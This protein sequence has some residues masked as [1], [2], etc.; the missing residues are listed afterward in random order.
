MRIRVVLDANIYAS[1]LMK[2]EGSPA[3]V[4]HTIISSEEYELVLSKDIQDE[5]KRILFYPKIRSRIKRTD[6]DL[7]KW[8]DALSILGHIVV[9]KYKYDVLVKEDPDDDI[10]L[11]AAIEGK[12]SYIVS[13]DNH[14]LKME[15]FENIQL[16]TAAAFL[17]QFS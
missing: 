17:Q 15:S 16:L 3:K 9:P 7:L 10:Y 13:G 11:I 1:A 14:L 8:M 2:A 4:L 12:A 6:E 5:L